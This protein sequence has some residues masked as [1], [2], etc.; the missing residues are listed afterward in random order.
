MYR[1]FSWSDKWWLCSN[2]RHGNG[3]NVLRV[4]FDVVYIV[5]GNNK[6][7]TNN[8]FCMDLSLKQEFGFMARI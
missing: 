2:L 7:K 6:W 4:R 8:T 1:D 3:E 5:F